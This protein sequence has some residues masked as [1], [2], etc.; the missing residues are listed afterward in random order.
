MVTVANCSTLPDALSVKIALDAAGIE[1]FI[2]DESIAVSA[3]HLI[4]AT[5]SGVR[6]QVAEEDEERAKLV[7]AESRKADSET[8]GEE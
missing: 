7:I 2:P 1:S 4:F 3:P 6:V 5:K 8:A